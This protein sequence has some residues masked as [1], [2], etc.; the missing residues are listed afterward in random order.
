MNC[1]LVTS[2]QQGHL[3]VVRLLV[4]GYDA[5][6]R[7]F[8]IHSNEFAVITGQPLYAAA[9]AGRS[10]QT[11]LLQN[12]LNV[13]GLCHSQLLPRQ[14]LAAAAILSGVDSKDNQL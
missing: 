8:A 11:S 9:R 4:R 13:T 5:D 1:M 7:D 12:Y 6:V 10:N 3:D 2:S 14:T